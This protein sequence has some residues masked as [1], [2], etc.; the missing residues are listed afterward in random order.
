MTLRG[1]DPRKI[2][3]RLLKTQRGSMPER[4]ILWEK[5][6]FILFY[7]ILFLSFT[8]FLK[9]IIGDMNLFMSHEG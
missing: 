9:D 6:T 1:R 8:L 7:F 4:K 3:D 2:Q 5:I